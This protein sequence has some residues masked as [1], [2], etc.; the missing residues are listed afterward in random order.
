[1]NAKR[2]A[3]GSIGA[4]ATNSDTN[5]LPANFGILL[6]KIRS[7]RLVEIRNIAA[8]NLAMAQL[9][10][11]QYLQATE[12]GPRTQILP[13]ALAAKAMKVMTFSSGTMYAKSGA[14]QSVWIWA[15]LV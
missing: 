14:R 7:T 11:R 5:S 6:S 12:A 4:E 2:T 8:S 13:V 1:M 9:P 10:L 3:A 15:A